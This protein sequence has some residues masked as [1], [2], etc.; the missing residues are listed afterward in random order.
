MCLIPCKNFHTLRKFIYYKQVVRASLNR[1][2]KCHGVSGS[3]NLKTCWKRLAPFSVVG[4]KL[5]EIYFKAA[6]V[7]FQNNM[8]QE[9]VKKQPRAVSGKEKKL[10]YLD[11]SPDYCVRNDSVGSPGMMGRTCRNDEVS[12]SKCRSLCNSCKMRHQTVEHF[13]QVKCKCKFVWCC[14]VKCEICPEKFSVT[15]CTR[16]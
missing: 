10:V 15:T 13:K 3:C 9:R 11:S 8:L 16:R 4:S 5:K 12:T 6:R 14:R 1:E 2:C 7:S